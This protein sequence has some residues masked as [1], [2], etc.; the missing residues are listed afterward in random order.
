M[1]ID[2]RYSPYLFDNNDVHLFESEVDILYLDVTFGEPIYNFPNRVTQ[3]LV[4]VHANSFLKE[5]VYK[6]ISKVIQ[7][8]S[9][10]RILI[11]VDNLGK[12][13][14]L[15]VLAQEFNTKVSH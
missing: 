8:H 4:K 10:H 11:G 7:D 5:E 3:T 2:I 14:L 6:Q 1:L 12:E 9:G 15:A 13:E